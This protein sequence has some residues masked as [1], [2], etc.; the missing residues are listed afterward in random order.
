MKSYTSNECYR[1]LDVDPKT[2]REWLK[3][4][5]VKMRQSQA[6]ARVKYLTEDE[7]KAM[8][9]RHGRPWPPIP[10]AVEVIPPS[11]YKLLLEQTAQAAQQGHEAS[12][13]LKGLEEQIATI[14]QNGQEQATLRNQE[15]EALRQDT[16]AQ[17]AAI[18]QRQDERD[19]ADIERSNTV[20][21]TVEL[22]TTML[23]EIDAAQQEAK[24]RIDVLVGTAG[25]HQQETAALQ[26]EQKQARADLDTLTEASQEQAEQLTVRLERITSAIDGTGRDLAAL[27]IRQQ[28]ALEQAQKAMQDQ[29]EQIKAEAQERLQ[30]ALKGMKA[31]YQSAVQVA[32]KEIRGEL[33][34]QA[35]ELYTALHNVEQEEA[36]DVQTLTAASEQQS[37]RVDVLRQ[38]VEQ[39]RASAQ[40]ANAVALES[41]KR[42]E[43][44]EQRLDHLEHVPITEQPKPKPPT[45]RRNKTTPQ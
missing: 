9:A 27:E 42:L 10:Q 23:K 32:H 34:Q 36:R 16:V 14:V 3:H 40:A 33:E 39:A 7:V 18:Q 41:Q 26:T 5:E 11:S 15:L 20:L 19:Q 30:Q 21:R 6:D 31:E 8:A 24:T 12:V 37:G 38:Q 45:T 13:A 22:A 25:R 29:L 43:A 28:A 17:L 4:D 44:L 35:R 2:F 1:A